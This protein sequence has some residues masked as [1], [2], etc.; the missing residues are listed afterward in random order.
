MAA[1]G[2]GGGD[3]QM[4]GGE[5]EIESSSPGMNKPQRHSIGNVVN[6]AAIA[7]YGDRWQLHVL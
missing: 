1:R 3:G 2:K 4:E 6:D 7:C 5:W